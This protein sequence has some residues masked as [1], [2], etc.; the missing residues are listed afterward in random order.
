MTDDPVRA[1]VPLLSRSLRAAFNVFDVMHH[2]MHEKQL[3]NAFAWLLDIDGTHKLGTTFQRIFVDE[4]NRA[5]VGLEPFPSGPFVVRQE[6]NTSDLGEN[7]DIADL[8]LETDRAMLVIENYYTSDGHGHDYHRYLNFGQRAGRRG[9]VVLLCRDE[10]SSAQTGGWEH[11]AV[12]TYATLITRLHRELARDWQYQ[13]SHPEPWSF[14]EQMHRKFVTRRSRVEDADVLDFV[15]AMCATGE[16][17]RYGLLPQ[18]SAAMA[19]G[20]DIARQAVERFGEG[21]ELLQRVKGRL[22]TY[23]DGVLRRQLEATFGQGCVGDVGA[24]YRGIYQWT[25]LLEVCAGGTMPSEPNI[26]VMFG[27]SAWYADEQDDYWK[28][29]VD[30]AV[31]DYSHLFV[32]DVENRT[33]RQSALTLQDV[34]A[35]IP[36]TD[37][38]LHDELGQLITPSH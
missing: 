3:S 24:N 12:V 25:V 20:E 16:A 14:I 29:T 8:V 33:I 17:G 7:A 2:G 30:I 1:L 23:C 11:A 22:R 13:E 15:T 27:P 18:D 35:G 36:T 4:V 10:D 37:L 6:V 19:F 31:T 21:R 26:H 28:T 38:R 34:L 9:A 5:R 32:A